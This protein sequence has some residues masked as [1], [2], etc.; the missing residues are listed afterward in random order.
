MCVLRLC[1]SIALIFSFAAIG[2]QS[3]KAEGFFDF[4]L[5]SIAKKGSNPAVTLKAPFADED[6]V[7]EEMDASGNAANQTPLHLR[8]R[9]NDIVTLWVQRIVPDMISYKAQ[10]Y[11]G[12]YAEKIKSFNEAGLSE[13][14]KFLGERNFVKT[15]KT[16]RYDIAGFI[17]D[18]PVIFNEGAIDGHYRW[19][20]QV[21]IMVTYIESGANDYSDIKKS[22]AISQEFVLTFQLGR[23][24]EATNDIGLL[25]ESWDVKPKKK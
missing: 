4:F 7:I 16:G 10:G 3:A 1:F 8:H 25:I 14:I 24:R 12:Q 2:G 6:A 21:N 9:T 13:Y 11:N 5:P 19:L 18:Y 20:Y 22:A 17:K 15:L 23:S